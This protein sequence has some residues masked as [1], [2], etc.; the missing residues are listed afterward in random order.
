MRRED[1]NNL[2]GHADNSVTGKH[3]AKVT[4]DDLRPVLQAI[5]NEIERLM[6]EGVGAKVIDCESACNNDPPLAL[7]G[8]QN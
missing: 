2:T 6:V 5:A 8:V 7:I 3:Y 1:I 4:P